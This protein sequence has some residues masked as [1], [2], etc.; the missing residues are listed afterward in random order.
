MNKPDDPNATADHPPVDSVGVCDALRTTDHVPGSDGTG[1]S[2]PA[3][4]SGVHASTADFPVVPGYRVNREI[5][6]GGMG[7]VLA[8]HDLMLERDVA[9]RVLL[10]GAKPTASSA[11][12][13]SPRGCRTQA[14]RRSTRSGRWR[15]ARPYL[16][17]GRSCERYRSPGPVRD[18]FAGGPH[19]LLPRDCGPISSRSSLRR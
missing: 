1:D 15:T 5:A 6:R 12:R 18:T 17:G 10:P 9:L 14:F 19:R 2:L 11:S 16:I 13:R 7:R 4:P 3:I 8:A